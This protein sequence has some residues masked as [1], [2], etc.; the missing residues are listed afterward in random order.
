MRGNGPRTP[1]P[2]LSSSGG[3]A[4]QTVNAPVAFARVGDLKPF[5][6]VLSGSENGCVVHSVDML[7]SVVQ[8][9]TAN[10]FFSNFGAVT[11]NPTNTGNFPYLSATIAPGY[12]KFKLK[13]LRL[14]YA[15]FCPTSQAGS[16]LLWA[17]PDA[18]TAPP[19]TSITMLNDSNTA[20]G[21]VYEDLQLNVDLRG[22][23]QDWL[24]VGTSATDNRLNSAGVVSV[25]TDKNPTNASPLGVGDFYI[26]SVWEFAG[27]KLPS[28]NEPV[29]LF[30]AIATS[31]ADPAARRKMLHDLVERIPLSTIKATREEETLE[32][33]IARRM[34][35]LG[36]GPRVAGKFSSPLTGP[37]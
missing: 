13:M 8:T 25:A 29:A 7:G 11:L 12:E 18:L 5:F 6:K 35:A 22:F 21:A 15:H 4:V 34:S 1:K 16:V 2:S 36:C 24:Y 10:T 30:R 31:D 32:E 27:R 14:H 28:L 19:S 23:T 9:T 37:R 33:M 20:E 26:E 3:P 17:N